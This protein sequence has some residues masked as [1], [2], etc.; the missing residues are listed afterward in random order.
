MSTLKICTLSR[1]YWITEVTGV[2]LLRS[3]PI[4]DG[5]KTTE[6]DALAFAGDFGPP[7]KVYSFTDFDGQGVDRVGNVLSI[8]KVGGSETW[9]VPSGAAFLMSDSGKTIDR[10]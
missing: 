1:T 7:P 5:A 2:Q 9:L 4:P 10:I 8:D 3:F 6:V